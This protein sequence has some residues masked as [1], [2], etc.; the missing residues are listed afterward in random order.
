[1]GEGVFFISSQFLYSVPTHFGSQF[2]KNHKI[3]LFDLCSYFDV[4]AFCE[5][6][7]KILPCYFFT[8][9]EKMIYTSPYSNLWSLV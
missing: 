8:V 5:E 2:C 4:S 6:T 1:M 7:L 3:D 9:N